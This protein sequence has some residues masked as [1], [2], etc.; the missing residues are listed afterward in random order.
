MQL[1]KQQ[2]TQNLKEHQGEQFLSGTQKIKIQQLCWHFFKY[3]NYNKKT[4]Q[5]N[6]NFKNKGSSVEKDYSH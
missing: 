3:K 5:F 4:S 1:V 2:A 6:H